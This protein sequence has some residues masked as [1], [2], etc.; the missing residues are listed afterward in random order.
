[1]RAIKQIAVGS[2]PEGAVIALCEDNT[3]W[4]KYPK[5]TSWYPISGI[6]Q[7]EEKV[8]RGTSDQPIITWR[9]TAYQVAGHRFIRTGDIYLCLDGSMAL[10]ANCDKDY[11]RILLQRI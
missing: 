10:K 9:N 4:A 1:M 2:S 8:P 11:H 6:P 3:L 5:D 7:Q